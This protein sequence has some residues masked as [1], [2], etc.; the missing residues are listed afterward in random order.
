[1]SSKT[2]HTFFLFCIAAAIAY[3]LVMLGSQDWFGRMASWPFYQDWILST[4]SAFLVI[5]YFDWINRKLDIHH[6]WVDNWKSRLLRQF[7]LLV[8]LPAGM[9]ILIT[10][11]QYTFLY[12]QNLITH[13]Y[14]QNEF[15]VTV[16][17]IAVLNLVYFIAY[18]LGLRRTEATTTPNEA[19]GTDFV[20]IG[21]KGVQKI[22]VQPGEIAYIR[23]KSRILFLTRFD[24]ETLIMSENLDHYEKMLPPEHFFRANRQ[25]IIHREACRAYEPIENGKIRLALHPPTDDLVTISQ[26][27]AAKFREWIRN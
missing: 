13:E 21:Q 5:L 1:M 6:A 25:L 9:A 3:I 2:K 23:L 18:L 27:K 7:V 10:W 12:D 19:D 16:L 20:L 8:I 11:L 15:V 24:K 14:F 26:K 17:I 22:P 4:L